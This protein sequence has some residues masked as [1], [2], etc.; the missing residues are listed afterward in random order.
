MFRHIKCFM[1]FST[2][3]YQTYIVGENLINMIWESLDVDPAFQYFAVSP[4]IFIH[5]LVFFSNKNIL[6]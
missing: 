1:L 4:S 6:T 2:P 5:I 3:A